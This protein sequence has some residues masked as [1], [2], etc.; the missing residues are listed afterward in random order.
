VCMSVLTLR[1]PHHPPD[2]YFDP[3]R[4]VARAPPPAAWILEP[5]EAPP[6]PV[7]KP[8]IVERTQEPNGYQQALQEGRQP[9]PGTAAVDGAQWLPLVVAMATLAMGVYRR[10]RHTLDAVDRY[11]L[12]P[13]PSPPPFAYQGKH[14]K[15]AGR[16]KVE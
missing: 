16:G 15:Q 6:S 14:E 7:A 10:R 3:G 13:S 1:L 9:E 5:A 2:G 4:Y 11:P 12:R 8:W